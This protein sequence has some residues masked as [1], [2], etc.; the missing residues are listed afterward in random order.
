MKLHPL[1]L[2]LERQPGPLRAQVEAALGAHGR[3]LRWAITAASAER[4]QVEA[5]VI[6][7]EP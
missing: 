5:V 1:T 2:D 6:A 7:P 4:L 3:P